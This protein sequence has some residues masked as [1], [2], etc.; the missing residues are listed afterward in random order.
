MSKN[1]FWSPAKP[2]R[3]LILNFKNPVKITSREY[4]SIKFSE[5][6]QAASQHP[7]SLDVEVWYKF[8]KQNTFSGQVNPDE[9][10]VFFTNTPCETWCDQI[11]FRFKN[12][13]EKIRIEII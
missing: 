11:M 12:K 13:I 8:K 6:I 9:E 1:I 2:E 7:N 5:V 3:V 4:L 10:K